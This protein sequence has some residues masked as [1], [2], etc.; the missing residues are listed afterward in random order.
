MPGGGSKTLNMTGYQWWSEATHGV[1]HY[2]GA[3]EETHGKDTTTEYMTNFPF[4]ITTAMSFNRS[5]W[6]ATGAQIGREARAAMNVG[7]AYST[8]W[9]PVVNMA[10]GEFFPIAT[11]SSF[12]YSKLTHCSCHVLAT[13]S[14][15]D[16]RWGRNLEAVGEDPTVTAEYAEFFVKGMQEN[17]AEPRFWQA[18]ACCKH[19]AGNSVE[20]ATETGITWGR[21]TMSVNISQRDLHEYY[22]RPYQSCV[23]RA[24]GEHSTA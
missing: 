5:L 22:L 6:H 19:Y 12:S 2:Y 17:P 16:P 21:D 20:G 8:F 24:N 3:P 18:G 15:S 4:P 13:A 1:S 11:S 9:T 23:E 7:N 14:G 10:R